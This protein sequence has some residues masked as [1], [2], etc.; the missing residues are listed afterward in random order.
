M[1]AADRGKIHPS[2]FSGEELSKFY[3][4]TEQDKITPL[5]NKDL[6]PLGSPRINDCNI[7]NVERLTYKGMLVLVIEIPYQQDEEWAIYKAHA[8]TSYSLNK[9][10]SYRVNTTNRYI[11]INRRRNEAILIDP[12]SYSKHKICNYMSY[13]NDVT[14][15]QNSPVCELELFFHRPYPPCTII[16]QNTRN[17]KNFIQTLSGIITS[18]AKPTLIKIQYG[19]LVEIRSIRDIAIFQLPPICSLELDGNIF[20]GSLNTKKFI[21]PPNIL[22]AITLNQLPDPMGLTRVLKWKETDWLITILCAAG[23]SLAITAIIMIGI[24]RY[25]LTEPD[26]PNL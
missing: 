12:V 5:T 22:E 10:L 26:S 20:S 11:G 4:Q 23:I 1:N 3:Q 13:I 25:C 2:L 15:P 14:Q 24:K 8:P 19:S 7:F 6:N 17:K 9:T 18:V 16:T 21:I